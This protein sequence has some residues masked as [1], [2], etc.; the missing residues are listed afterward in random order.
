MNP[1]FNELL[2]FTEHPSDTV[3]AI[4]PD[5]RFRTWD[6]F[7]RDVKECSAFLATGNRKVVIYSEDPYIFS[8]AFA[9][10][11]QTN[12]DIYLPGF[13][14]ES[15]FHDV[16]VEDALFLGDGS[17]PGFRDVRK[18]PEPSGT[19]PARK[20][21]RIILMTSGSTGEPKLINKD[22]RQFRDEVAVLAGLWESR[23][24][25]SV[26]CSTVSHQHFYGLLFSVLVPMASG[27]P[28]LREAD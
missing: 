24:K 9:A 12:R 13:V 3:L 7:L 18:L 1:Q 14:G 5:G 20:A 25:S 22:V 26:V 15:L 8:I 10:S 17:I 28:F 6:D 23:F 2:G 11:I 21:G 4:D 16:S 27:V 19:F